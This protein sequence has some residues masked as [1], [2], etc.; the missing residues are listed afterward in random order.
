[1][2]EII[3]DCETTG[4]DP[5]NG[6]RII[7]LAAVELDGVRIGG[8]WHSLFDPERQIDQEAIDVHGITNADLKGQPTFKSQVESFLE[9]IEG[10]TLIAHNAPFDRGFLTAEMWRCGRA[11]WRAEWID[12]LPLARKKIARKGHTLDALCKHYGIR[13]S[14]RKVHGAILDTLLLA[15]VYVRLVGRLDQLQ[16]DGM[17][18]GERVWLRG[19]ELLI[20]AACDTPHPGQRPEPLPS[21]LTLE[22]LRAHKCFMQQLEKDRHNNAEINE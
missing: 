19:G 10:A 1:M 15:E 17:Q 13:K 6:H 8:R 12:T 2:R 3:L 4:L 21:G 20:V 14:A 11:N 18:G 7:E 5:R 22:E 9:F 16:L